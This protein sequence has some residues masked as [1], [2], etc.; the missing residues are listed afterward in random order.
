[1]TTPEEREEIGEVIAEDAAER[2]GMITVMTSA[3]EACRLHPDDVTISFGSINADLRQQLA[4]V[5]HERDLLRA[6]LKR[7]INSG[8]LYFEQDAP[9]DIEELEADVCAALK[10]YAEVKA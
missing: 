1:M 3:G 10:P 2:K 7:V 9:D 5:S 6:L 8:V 4:D